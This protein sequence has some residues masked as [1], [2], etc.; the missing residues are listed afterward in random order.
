[1][2]FSYLPPLT[3]RMAYLKRRKAD[4]LKLKSAIEVKNFK[5]IEN[6][7]HQIKGTADS[8]GFSSLTKCASELEQAAKIENQFESSIAADELAKIVQSLAFDAP[9]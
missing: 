9:I 7:G 6:L 4:V 3:L 8:F 1:M 5:F 2:P